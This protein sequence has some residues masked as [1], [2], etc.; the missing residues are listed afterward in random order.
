M[1]WILGALGLAAVLALGWAAFRHLDDRPVGRK[2]A[3]RAP[4]PVSV[5][6][7]ERGRIERHRVFSGTL[8]ASAR[9]VV[10]A[11]VS[12]RV[13][14]VHVELADRVARGQV[15][16]EL[17]DAEYAQAVE[18]AKAEQAVAEA[19]LAEANSALTIAERVLKRARG[20]RDRGVTSPAQLDTAE[21]EHLVRTAAV[22]VARAQVQRARA[23]LAAAQVRLGY[24]KVTADW[25]ADDA[26]RVVAA[27][28]VDPGATV[29]AQT[30]LLTIVD[31]D[32]LT[33][34][35][36]AAEAD[37]AHLA[38]LTAIEITTD[39]FPG[40]VFAGHIARVAP[41][42]GET[43]RQARVELHVDN[44]GHDL[45]P[46]MFIRA[47]ATLDAA[48]DARIVPL[49]ALTV[50]GGV[51]G[52]FVLDADGQTARWRPV[53]VGLRDAGRVQISGDGLTGQVVTLG[54]QLIDDG[55][56]VVLAEVGPTDA[57]PPN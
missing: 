37:Y 17:D 12:G 13:A 35:I 1:R 4:A 43:T 14:R 41:V 42:F 10:A 56:P 21:A 2:A 25:P 47:R 31:L 44:P 55:S 29:A 26:D 28:A 22:K 11:K 45:R 16:V 30:P 15:V 39:A 7:I 5:A 23:G 40:R 50:R 52:V 48:A 8:E 18:Q 20:L 9:F 19:Q 3:V 54:Q 57:G 38:P 33:G 34:V 32:P 46:G 6:P 53:M 24:T 49:E 27:R 36:F 51:D